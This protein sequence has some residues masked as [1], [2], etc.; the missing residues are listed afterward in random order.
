MGLQRPDL[1]VMKDGRIIPGPPEGLVNAGTG[2]MIVELTKTSRQVYY[3][4]L[5]IRL[6]STYA[7]RQLYRMITDDEFILA[8][9]H[10]GEVVF[11]FPLPLVALPGSGRLVNSYAIRGVSLTNPDPNW[12]RRHALAQTEWAKRA[13]DTSGLRI[14]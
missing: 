11:S 8:E 7:G 9:P 2:G 13:D 14:K 3:H 12:Q 10:S 6:P 1:M 4:G 5:Y